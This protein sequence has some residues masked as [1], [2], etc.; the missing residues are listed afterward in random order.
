MPGYQTPH[1]PSTQQSETFTRHSSWI[2][3]EDII[4]ESLK[5]SAKIMVLISYLSFLPKKVGE[6]SF[7]VDVNIYNFEDNTKVGEMTY[8]PAFP[9]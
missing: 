8:A 3:L 1:L 2:Q 9:C 5:N 7:E 4:Q 6:F